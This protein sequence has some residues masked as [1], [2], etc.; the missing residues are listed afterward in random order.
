MKTKL[1]LCA[2]LLGL[3]GGCVAHRPSESPYPY[4]VYPLGYYHHDHYWHKHHARPYHHHYYH[5]YG[6]H[7][8]EGGWCYYVK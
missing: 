1:L 6:H 8:C 2:V 3:L 5:R 4:G 7:Y